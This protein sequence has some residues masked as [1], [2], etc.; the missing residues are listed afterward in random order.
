VETES[1]GLRDRLQ[2]ALGRAYTL[3]RELGGGGMSRVF[4]AHDTRLARQV[5]VKVLHPDLIA[6]LSAR[7]FEREVTLAARLQH[8]HLVPV[9]AAGEVDGLPFYTMPFVQGESLRGRLRREGALPVPDA[10]R[11]LREL[12]DALAY[13]HGEGVVHRDLKPENVLLSGAHAGAHAMIADFG[14]AKALASATRRDGDGSDGARTATS[15]ALGI[16]VGTPAYMAPEQAAAD[17]AT[18]HRADLYALGLIAYEALAGAHPFGGRTPQ[19]MLAAHLVETPTPLPERC[20]VAPPALAALVARLLAKRP[21]ERPQSAD[22]V[23]RVLD[24]LT[25]PAGRTVRPARAAGRRRR[26]IVAALLGGTLALAGVGV[27][28]RGRR[29]VSPRSERSEPSTRTVAAGLVKGRVVVA[30]FANQTA[31]TALAP[32]GRLTGDWI[33]Q[34]LAEAG[35]AEV[36]DPETVRSTWQAKPDARRLALAT[37]ARLVVSGAYYLEGDTLRLLARISDAADNRV[38][39]AVEPVSAPVVAPRQAVARLRDRVLGALGGL[40]AVRPEEWTLASALPPSLAAYRHF[41]AGGEH[42]ARYDFSAA[43]REY[44]AAHRV[45]STFVQPLLWAGIAQ[46]L[47]GAPATADSLFRVADRSRERL[48]PADRHLLDVLW[49]EARGDFPG[50]LRAAREMARVAPTS[51]AALLSVG[52]QGTRA[53]RPAEAV[54]ALLRLD[55]EGPGLRQYAGYWEALTQAYHLLGDYRAEVAAAQRGRASTPTVSPRSTTR[56][57][58]WPPS[59]GSPTSS[60]GSTRSS[61]CPRTRATGPWRWSRRSAASSARTGT[62]RRPRRRTR[63]RFAGTTSAPPRSARRRP[64]V[65]ATRRRSM[66]RAA[67]RRRSGSSSNSGRCPL[68]AGTTR[69][70]SAPC[71]EPQRTT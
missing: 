53:N 65:R 29:P 69:V 20:P 46:N 23:V 2:A 59:G 28:V 25:T 36:V 10:V 6:G 67:S 31:D 30:P 40:L 12:A 43:A 68:P 50:A 17:P 45:D 39:R 8:P 57:A 4:L 26:R 51:T 19:A 1:A 9:H 16:A 42:F 44:L 49:A 21:E 48:A 14:I 64:S 24:D 66:R 37:G 7:R 15:T 5:V 35:F 33:T 70:T 61:T 71:P 38:L 27:L 11:L 58:L 18:D 41:T 52:W 47:A 54:A 55:P 22:E 60:A 56:R 63:A 34:G 32:L 13:A 62:R 3:E